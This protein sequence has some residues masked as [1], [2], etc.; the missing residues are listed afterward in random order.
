RKIFDATMRTHR[1]LERC[2]AALAES[3]RPRRGVLFGIVQGG[4]EPDLRKLSAEFVAASNVSGIA[5]GGLSVGETKAE[6]AA[7]LDIVVPE[8]PVDKP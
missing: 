4:M 2:V 7:M 1:W 8:L 3:E 5:I 6:M